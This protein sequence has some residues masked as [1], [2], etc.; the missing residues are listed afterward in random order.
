M[1]KYGYR[2]LIRSVEH[3]RRGRSLWPAGAPSRSFDDKLK[4]TRSWASTPCSSTTTTPCPVWMSCR[5]QRSAP[6][7]RK[8]RQ[9]LDD[10]GLSRRVRRPAPVGASHD[11]RR[12]Y[13]ANDPQARA[14]AIERSKSAADIAQELGTDLMV[15]GWRA[16]APTCARPRTWCQ[17]TSTWRPSTP[18]WPTIPA[19]HRHR[20]QAERAHGPGLHPD[21]GTC[22]GAGL[23]G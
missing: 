1:E 2:F 5:R 21:H 12:R 17:Q 6:G 23:P 8:V 9:Q 7:P 10:H 13:T 16:K 20:T 11:H 4:S 15:S 19:A 22:P 18:C 14:Y 3:P